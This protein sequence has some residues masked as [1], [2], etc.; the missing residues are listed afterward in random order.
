Y[1][2]ESLF[3]YHPFYPYSVDSKTHKRKKAAVSISRISFEKNT[4]L[5]RVS[6][7]KNT[8]IIIKAN[9]LLSRREDIIKLYGCA[10]RMY[11]HL[12]LG[13]Y[14]GDFGKYYCGIFD[15]SFS[16]ISNLLAGV[17]FVVDLSVL[18]QDGGGTQ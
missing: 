5:S 14:N 8:D 3:L 1:S 17:K 9:N 16:A 6:F 11:V 2:L 12:S 10:S 4:P 15:K 7:E 13:R 18:K